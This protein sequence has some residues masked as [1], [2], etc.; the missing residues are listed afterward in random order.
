[1]PSQ[2]CAW[3]MTLNLKSAHTKMRRGREL[4]DGL[5]TEIQSWSQSVPYEITPQR[6]EEGTIFVAILTFNAWPDLDRWAAIAGDIIGNYRDALDHIIYALACEREGKDPPTYEQR[7]MF[8]ICND[9]KSFKSALKQNRLGT[10]ADRQDFVDMIKG[11]QPYEGRE[12]LLE[13]LRALHDAHKH[14]QIRAVVL[15]VPHF[16]IRSEVEVGS[17]MAIWDGPLQRITPFVQLEYSTPRAGVVLNIQATVRI[18]FA[19]E[20]LKDKAG[21][22]LPLLTVLALLQETVRRVHATLVYGG[23]VTP[24]QA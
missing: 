14:R 21:T 22:D 1:M 11:L 24:T 20:P 6:N 18:A 15:G 10:L 12:P 17:S 9:P 5:R 7:L 19:E 2:Y 3:P 13:R 8:P 4:L 16:D 23:R